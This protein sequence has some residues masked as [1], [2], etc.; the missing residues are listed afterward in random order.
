MVYREGPPKKDIN[1]K[2]R[3]GERE[4]DR[5]V[6]SQFFL[7]EQVEDIHLKQDPPLVAGILPQGHDVCSSEDERSLLLS[8]FFIINNIDISNS[9]LFSTNYLELAI[10]QSVLFSIF[11]AGLLLA[12]R[13]ASRAWQ[14]LHSEE[15]LFP[16]GFCQ[17]CRKAAA[18][19]MLALDALLHNRMAALNPAVQTWTFVDNC[20]G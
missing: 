11:L 10:F 20:L 8:S 13:V 4:R 12:L 17:G 3:W 16:V 19:G 15:F 5:K 1:K 18:L 7:T 9:S 14:K 6:S 2:R